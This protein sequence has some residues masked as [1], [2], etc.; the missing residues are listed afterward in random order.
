MSSR[1]RRAT[2]FYS[3]VARMTFFFTACSVLWL[4]GNGPAYAQAARAQQMSDQTVRLWSLADGTERGASLRQLGNVNSLAYSPDGKLL[5][6]ASGDGTIRLWETLGGNLLAI[7]EGHKQSVESVAFSPDGR[8]LVSGGW[9]GD[10][11]IWN[12]QSRQLLKTLRGHEGGVWSVAFSPDGK[13]VASGGVD[14]T[15]RIW[16]AEDGRPIAVLRDH[17]DEVTTVAFSPHGKILATGSRDQTV[18]LWSS[19]NGLRLG[20]IR[21]PYKDAIETIAFSPDGKILA[22]GSRDQTIKLWSL[23]DGRELRTFLGHTSTVNLIAFSPDGKTLASGSYD[24]TIKIWDVGSG[25]EL[26][27]LTGHNQQITAISFSPDGMTLASG[28]ALSRNDNPTLHVLAIGIDRFQNPSLNLLLAVKDAQDVAKGLEELGRTGFE[29]INTKVLVDAEATRGGIIDALNEMASVVKPQDTFV[30]FYS[31]RGDL[32]KQRQNNAE[33]FLLMPFDGPGTTGETTI[34]ASLLSALFFKI[35]AQHQLIILDTNNG[36]KGFDSLVTRFTEEN[37]TLEGLFQRD[38]VLLATGMSYEDT[39][40]KNGALTSALLEGMKGEAA[41][42]SGEIS[43]RSLSLY[44]NNLMVNLQ[45][46]HPNLEFKTYE[47][48][49]DFILGT[50]ARARTSY[51]PVPRAGILTRFTRPVSPRRETLNGRAAIYPVSYN[52]ERGGPLGWGEQEG[53]APARPDPQ[54]ETKRAPD[55]VDDTPAQAAFPR[56]GKDYALIIGVSDYV[57]WKTLPNPVLDA[58]A[59]EKELREVYGFETQLLKDPTK[60]DIVNALRKYRHEINY[61]DDDQL[62]IFFAGHGYFNEDYKEGYLIVKDSLKQDEIGDSYFAHSILRKIV[63]NIPCKHI[64]LMIDS[65]YSGTIDEAIAR[66][67]EEPYAEATNLEFIRR[68]M[69]YKTRQ[70]LTSGGKEYVYDGRP[71]Q[72]SPF[73]RKVL[74]ALR[75]AGGKD[76]ILT[77]NGILSYVE[78]VI[79]EPRK[80][81]FG[82]NEPGSDFLFIV[83]KNPPPQ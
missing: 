23:F 7:L 51:W 20:N 45:P 22:T 68:K 5:A 15:A 44:V 12:V 38:L 72:H 69:Q 11:R 66:R 61:T 53:N 70:V 79:P 2:T 33:E 16:D 47:I 29:R 32:S 17:R 83:K 26:R 49:G 62:F 19:E 77:I 24:Q 74:E 10:V 52:P 8:L 28:S 80:G 37:R 21:L 31:G 30:F 59:V 35:E 50:V 81:E 57:Y 6:V 40:L 54:Q 55:V 63:D 1:K 3:T 78:R 67:G 76:G 65:C 60:Q 58:E 48:G 64:F 46:R 4:F 71:G 41:N 43:S 18:K 9:D 75:S 73:A 82:T 42:N 36:N 27:S 56:S 25:K 34:S 39:G 14:H 13:L